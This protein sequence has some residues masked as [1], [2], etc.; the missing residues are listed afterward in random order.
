MTSEQC[1]WGAGWLGGVVSPPR[2]H[3]REC[4]GIQGN[5]KGMQENHRMPDFD[6]TLTGRT[7]TGFIRKSIITVIRI[8]V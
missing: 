3:P 2:E 4:K 1:N 6:T 7:S 8:N 5:H